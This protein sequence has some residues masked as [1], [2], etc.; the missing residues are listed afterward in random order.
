MKEIDIL[1][2]E[3][4]ASWW[5]SFIWFKWGQVLTGKYFAAKVRRKYARYKMSIIRK[6]ELEE[7]TVGQENK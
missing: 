3:V 1:Y 7:L 4:R 2:Y 6:Q 5:A